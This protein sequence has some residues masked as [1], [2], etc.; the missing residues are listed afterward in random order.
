[1]TSIRERVRTVKV[2]TRTTV[3]RD[4]RS[5]TV[6]KVRIVRKATRTKAKAKSKPQGVILYRGPSLIDGTPIVCV[7]TG[8]VR[9][10]KNPK[11][12]RGIQTYIL[13]DNGADPVQAWKDG[14]DRAICGDCPHRGTTC[15]VNIVQAPLA[16]YRAVKRGSYPVFN[17]RKHL[18]LFEDRFLRL[19]SY[20]DPAAVPLHVW[21]VVCAVTRN[22]TG[23][24]HQWSSCD[25][26]Y[27]RF[28]MASVET[29]LQRLEALAKGYRTFRVRLPHQAIEP[30]EFVCPASLEAG[31]RLTCEECKACS[32]AKAGRRNAT[33]VIYF[34]GSSIAGNRT[35]RLYEL[36]MARIEADEAKRIPLATVS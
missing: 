23:Y 16:V 18:H 13:A 15:Y 7:A 34:H 2:R 30:G 14:S 24:T 10:S 29:P 20:G 9:K 28:C 27:A 1:M 4:G 21:E 17:P 26:G 19:G 25:P 35:L 33:P 6:E 3:R 31:K 12:G 8:L 32:G 36:A 5:K 22:H 11:T